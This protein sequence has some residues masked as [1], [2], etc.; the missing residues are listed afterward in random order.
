MMEVLETETGTATVSIFK[1]ILHVLVTVIVAVTFISHIYLPHPAK[2]VAEAQKER[3][4]VSNNIQL[5][6]D[7]LLLRATQKDYL[8]SDG[9]TIT[10][11]IERL[12]KQEAELQQKYLAERE[13]TTISG[14]HS[15]HKFLWHFGIG[16]VILVFA[17]DMLRTL[18]YFK[19]VHRK[20]R[21]FRAFTAL[22]IAGYYM[23][24]IFYVNDDLPKN[25]YLHVLLAIGVLAGISGVY[26]AQV[27][28][29]SILWLKYKMLM[30]LSE[31]KNGH[32]KNI[33]KIAINADPYN[34]A[35]QDSLKKSSQKLSKKMQDEADEIINY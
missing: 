26:A 16:L 1:I 7:S 8:V 12:K 34:E 6:K 10:E 18:S 9:I 21:T 19:G 35:Y 24:W 31:L 2:N 15:P 4:S 17:L 20:A 13:K 22:T 23:A 28:R 14:F 5:L 25:V 27:K 32:I 3:N 11:H 29:K 33:Y 30:I